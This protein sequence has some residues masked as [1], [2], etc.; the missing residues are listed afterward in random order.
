MQA[1]PIGKQKIKPAMRRACQTFAWWLVLLCCFSACSNE[2]PE[3]EENVRLSGR[4]IVAYLVANNRHGVDLSPEFKQN[5]VWMYQSL[6]AMQD[7]CRLFVYFRPAVGDAQVAIPSLWEFIADG[8]GK[9]NDRQTE[10]GAVPSFEDVLHAARVIRL[11]DNNQNATSP[12]TMRQVFSDIRE[13]AHSSSYGLIC[14]SHATGWLPASQPSSRAFGDDDGYSMDVP[15]L[16]SALQ[17]GFGGNLDFVLFDACMMGT[18]EVAYEL[19][20][21]T[22]YSIGS[23]VET[24]I[25]GFPYHKMLHYLYEKEIPFDKVC[26]TFTAFVKENYPSWS[27]TCAA[28]RSEAMEE[29]AAVTRRE[30]SAHRSQLASSLYTRLQQY[31]V[32]ENGFGYFSFDMADL[33]RELNG[34]SVPEAVNDALGEAVVAKSCEAG[35]LPGGSE[36]ISADRF[37]GIG[38]YIPGAAGRERWDTYCRTSIAWYRAMGWDSLLN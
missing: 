27:A 26:T 37:G 21:V 17:A 1:S 28:F 32:R 22:N 18:A 8:H 11:Y 7:S 38:I 10:A 6:S 12:E 9:V 30:L 25:D 4:T 35:R 23:V 5:I 13:V 31:G 16:A 33:V 14:G 24:P 36:N 2:I 3:E 34:G 29:L 20:Y 15:V 19:R